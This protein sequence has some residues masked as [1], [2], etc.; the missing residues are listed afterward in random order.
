VKHH[1]DGLCEFLWEEMKAEPDE[2]TQELART[3]LG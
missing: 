2:E 1:Y 3:L